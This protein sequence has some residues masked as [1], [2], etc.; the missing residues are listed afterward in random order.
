MKLEQLEDGLNA[1]ERI[2]DA[3]EAIVVL[4]KPLAAPQ[5]LS[6]AA[7]ERWRDGG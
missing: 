7:N 3:L 2:A 4:L 1:V 5:F 6:V